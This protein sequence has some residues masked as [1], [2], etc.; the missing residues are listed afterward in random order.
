M[1]QPKSLT[2]VISLPDARLNFHLTFG[3]ETKDTLEISGEETKIIGNILNQAL[4]LSPEVQELLV[5]FADYIK[6]AAE[7]V[8]AGDGDGQGSD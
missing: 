8:R 4:R 3:D 2:G 1:R 5:K 7:K 6:D